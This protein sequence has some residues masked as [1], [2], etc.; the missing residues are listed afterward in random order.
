MKLKKRLDEVK[1]KTFQTQG[2]RH[3]MLTLKFQDLGG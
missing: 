3:A 1:M 2:A